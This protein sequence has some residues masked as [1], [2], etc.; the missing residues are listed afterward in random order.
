[1]DRDAAH[2]QTEL[3]RL[4]AEVGP[5]PADEPIAASTAMEGSFVW[6]CEHGRIEGRVLMAPTPAPQVQSLGFSVAL[7]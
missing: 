7:P 5:C 6:R 3:T 4:K 1:M 2:W